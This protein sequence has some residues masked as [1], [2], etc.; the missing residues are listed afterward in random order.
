MHTIPERVDDLDSLRSN[1]ALELIHQQE[2]HQER[3]NATDG[4]VPDEGSVRL[5][6]YPETPHVSS[7]FPIQARFPFPV[8]P[9]EPSGGVNCAPGIPSEPNIEA[10]TVAIRFPL[11]PQFHRSR[12]DT[13]GITSPHRSRD[14]SLVNR[15]AR[16]SATTDGG[17][18]IVTTRPKIQ[19]LDSLPKLGSPGNC[20]A[21]FDCT[22][23]GRRQPR[24]AEFVGTRGSDAGSMV[25]HLLITQWSP[26]CRV[27]RS[28]P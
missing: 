20:R 18:H 3:H 15:S 7:A 27:G 24:R 11:A 2:K 8:A 25:L 5:M 19:V 9:I 1:H 10:S 23:I 4:P 6:S 13:R 26:S 28:T 14:I 16:S 21:G 22:A 12:M 17:R